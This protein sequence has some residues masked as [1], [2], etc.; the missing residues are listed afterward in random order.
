MIVVIAVMLI[1]TTSHPTQA[2]DSTLA[3]YFPLATGNRWVYEGQDRTDGAPPAGEYWEVIREEP[4]A[5]V[6]RIRQ[7]I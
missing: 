2:D 1:P 5:F 7:V 3:Q 4:G 6:L